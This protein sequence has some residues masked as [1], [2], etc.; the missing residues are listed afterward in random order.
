MDLTYKAKKQE[1]NYPQR[2]S[3]IWFSRCWK[4]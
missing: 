4:S 2:S 1:L 3:R